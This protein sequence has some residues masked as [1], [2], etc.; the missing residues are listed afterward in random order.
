MEWKKIWEGKYVF[1]KLNN[2]AVYSGKVIEV[3]DSD[4][5]MIFFLIK[6]KF[7]K[8]VTFLHSEIIKIKEEGMD[9]GATN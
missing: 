8:N 4:K 2:Y 3:D 6:D 7:G 1:V 5:N 9:N